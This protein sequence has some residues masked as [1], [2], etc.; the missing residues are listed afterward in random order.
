MPS[1]PAIAIAAPR[2][3]AAA[4]PVAVLGAASGDADLFGRALNAATQGSMLAALPLS[5]GQANPS[6]PAG[7][8]TLDSARAAPS[9]PQ[10]FASLLQS[11]SGAASQTPGAATAVSA[12][13]AAAASVTNT[14]PSTKETAAT[15]KPAT[16]LQT[17]AASA[18]ASAAAAKT[19]FKQQA[20]A[21]KA[22]V[23]SQPVSTVSAALAGLQTTLQNAPNSVSASTAA[24][25][26]DL[27]KQASA[28]VTGGPGAMQARLATLN[29]K[30]NK[31]EARETG[32]DP[33]APP[34]GW[35]E[36][37]VFS[38]ARSLLSSLAGGTATTPAAMAAT[39][40]PL[41]TAGLPIA[42]A[43]AA[44]TATANAAAQ[45]TGTGV[46]Q[47]AQT[48]PI[49]AALQAAQATQSA[50]TA[51]LDPRMLKAAAG[52]TP[53]LLSAPAQ[54]TSASSSTSKEPSRVSAN[55]R[56]ASSSQTTTVADA[57]ANGAKVVTPA[58]PNK[59]AGGDDNASLAAEV[60]DQAVALAKDA[61]ADE[62][63]AM[64]VTSQAADAQAAQAQAQVQA[65]SS[66]QTQLQAQIQAQTQTEAV[67]TST[68]A[69]QAAPQATAYLAAQMVKQLDGRSTQF[70][71]QLHP[72]DLGRVDVQMRIQQDGKLNAQLAF[73]NPAAAAEFRGRSDEL[74][75]Q[76]QQAGFQV[77]DDS[78]TFSERNPQGFGQQPGF[79]QQSQNGGDQPDLRSRAFQ[80]SAINAQTADLAA[81]S[82]S[83]VVTGLD[84]RV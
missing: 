1:H 63:P 34:Q 53:G 21:L 64:T 50:G 44:P 5:R 61:K 78:L 18:T 4:A 81:S 7:F 56:D 14:S 11:A 31:L 6:G 46:T 82:S 28:G 75:Q 73:D 57:S 55:D 71:L 29:Q 47:S 15:T 77:S 9:I 83:R 52:P 3:A 8:A 13:T 23:Q 72:A 51:Q 43:P 74:R 25:V 20:A 59:D 48:G 42:G 68:G 67:Q 10:A 60:A 33:S 2:P 39:G 40:D 24:G 58:T 17:V 80:N 26:T 79:G 69:S 66:S 76:L 45:T 70:D 62:A 22:Q 12:A 35:T 84:M 27:L 36:P 16:A 38:Q 54:T 41:A 30:L 32:V 49:A 65:Q 19:N 37:P